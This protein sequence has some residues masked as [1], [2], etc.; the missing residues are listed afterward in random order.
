MQKSCPSC[1]A[2][3]IPG[4]RF[5]RRCGAPMQIAGGDG[6]GDVSPQAATVPL[7]SEEARTTDGLEPGEEAASADTSR[8]NHAEMER[9]LRL[10][11]NTDRQQ[12]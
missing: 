9:L 6:T 11:Q 8:V 3:I 2:E 1:G 4:A 12:P 5:C 10:G 7:N